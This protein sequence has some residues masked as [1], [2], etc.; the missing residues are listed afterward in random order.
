MEGK[1]SLTI[2]G[3]PSDCAHILRVAQRLASDSRTIFGESISELALISGLAEYLLKLTLSADSRPL[4]VSILLASQERIFSVDSSGAWREHHQAHIIASE[5]L[6]VPLSEA[7]RAVEWD[8]LSLEPARKAL[9]KIMRDVG[10]TGEDAPLWL[11]TIQPQT[12]VERFL[13]AL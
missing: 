10:A 3:L 11:S 8:T 12:G 4:A 2:L 6:E 7:I 13:S 5:D 1:Y 9:A